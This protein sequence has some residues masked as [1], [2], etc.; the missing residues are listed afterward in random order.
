MRDIDAV[1][2]DM[3]GLVPDHEMGLRAALMRCRS[4]ARYA[5]PESASVEWQRV[6]ATLAQHMGAPA[7]LT[8]Q[9]QLDVAACFTGRR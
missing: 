3:L 8:E 6:A 4:M 7:D 9:W 1:L 5:A 2:G